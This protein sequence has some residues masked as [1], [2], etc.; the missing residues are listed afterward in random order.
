MVH[1]MRPHLWCDCC[2]YYKTRTIQITPRMKTGARSRHKPTHYSVST[3]VL[4]SETWY[5]RNGERN[6]SQT[7]FFIETMRGH[8]RWNGAKAGN[9][10][11]AAEKCCNTKTVWEGNLT[12]ILDTVVADLQPTDL[13]L[14]RGWSPFSQVDLERVMQSKLLR[15]GKVNLVWKTYIASK[16]FRNPKRDPEDA[17]SMEFFRRLGWTIFDAWNITATLAFR[18]DYSDGCHAYCYIYNA[19]NVFFLQMLQCK[20]VLT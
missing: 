1:L 11:C 17:S 5:Y 18:S 16:V 15:S 10:T 2:R 20:N 12:H 7:F 4:N 14:S 6:L 19:F 3:P 9:V 8:W 13:I